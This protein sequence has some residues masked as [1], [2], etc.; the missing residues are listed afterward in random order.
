MIAMAKKIGVREL[1]ALSFEEIE[2]KA[3]ELRA[4]LAK[5]RALISSGTRPENP[6]K[7]RKTRRQIA[8]MLTIVNEKKGVKE[9]KTKEV[10][11][12]K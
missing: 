9:D 2:E 3:G 6:G 12:K 5:E 7:I 8:R 10:N 4:E 11:E 1:R